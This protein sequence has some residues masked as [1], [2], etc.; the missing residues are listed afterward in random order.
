[1]K[2]RTYLVFVLA[3]ILVGLFTG[4][5][6]AVTASGTDDNDSINGTN[7]ADIIGARGGDDVVSGLR[8]SDRL[9]GNTGNDRISGGLGKDELHG[10]YGNDALYS[11]GDH[12]SSRGYRDVVYCGPGHDFASIDRWDRIAKDCEEVR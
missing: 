7:Y 4:V 3:T 11:A 5:A 10:G 8:G 9:Y 1:M 2:H 12:R 6:L